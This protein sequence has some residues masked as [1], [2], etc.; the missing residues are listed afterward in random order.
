VRKLAERSEAAAKDTEVLIRESLRRVNEGTERSNE[1]AAS[2]KEITQN[3]G[4]MSNVIHEIYES[5]T[6]QRESVE[7]IGGGLGEISRVVQS[8]SAMSEESAA[9]S[10]ELSHHAESL[11]QKSAFFHFNKS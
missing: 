1:T 11:K 10:D 9:A 7:H 8:N 3:I 6:K 4:D 5:S 2:L